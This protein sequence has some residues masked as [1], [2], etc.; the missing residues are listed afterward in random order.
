MRLA[1]RKITGWN[2]V[3]HLIGWVTKGK[4]CHVEGVF[5]DGVWVGAVEKGLRFTKDISGNPD[6]WDFVLL[7]MNEKTE[8]F[9]R[10]LCE[11]HRGTKYDFAGLFSYIGFGLIRQDPSKAYCSE[12]WRDLLSRRLIE[13]LPAWWGERCPPSGKNGLYEILK[14]L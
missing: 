2:P 10:V 11:I 5:S 4:Y 8:D 14:S 1:F 7:D 13:I 12:F 6:K 9:L 3:R